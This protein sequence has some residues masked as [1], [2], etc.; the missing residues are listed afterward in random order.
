MNTALLRATFKRRVAEII[1][2]FNR[3]ER[4]DVAL[5]HGGIGGEPL[6]HT[7]RVNFLDDLIQALGWTL[8]AN[9]DLIQ[10]ARIQ[11]DTTNYIDY[12]GLNANRKPILIVEAKSWD[13]PFIGPSRASTHGRTDE[14]DLL[15]LAIRFIRTQQGTR[16]VLKEWHDW[17]VQV[18]GYVAD[19]KNAGH[20]VKRLVITSGQWMMIFTDPVQILCDGRDIHPGSNVFIFKI[21]Q[22]VDRSDGILNLLAKAV[23]AQ[24][25]PHYYRPTQ[26]GSYISA[27][28]LRGAFLSVMLKKADAGYR[29]YSPVPIINVAP[30]ILLVRDDEEILH[31]A[32]DPDEHIIIPHDYPDLPVHLNRL[33]AGSNALV[34]QV[35]QEL[36]TTI[37]ILPVT[38][39]PGFKD[40]L[41]RAP[42]IGGGLSALNRKFVRP[43]DNAVD[44]FLIATGQN[45]HYLLAAQPNQLCRFHDWTTCKTEQVAFGENPILKRNIHTPAS[46]FKSNEAHHCAQQLVHDRR[47]N[48]CQIAGFEEYVCCKR[49]TFEPVC[50]DDAERAQL[51]C[52]L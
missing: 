26:L 18:H 51:P 16:P 28:T 13:K 40:N 44:E 23:L 27:T 2:A 30:S 45:S 11:S 47:E 22:Y 46:F 39:F 7:T 29:S 8:N 50:W 37:S 25:H 1:D 17:L 33:Q 41:P 31:V 5:F 34:Q 52:E 9:H 14:Y 20:E 15:R 35:N 48:K 32:N 21:D 4:P 42:M 43:V 38:A 12:L 24:E 10:E 6:E 3:A 36:N 49:C 19:L